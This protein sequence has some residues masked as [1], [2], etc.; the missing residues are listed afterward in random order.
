M[1]STRLLQAAV[2]IGG[3]MLVRADYEVDVANRGWVP[4]FVSGPMSRQG[5]IGYWGALIHVACWITAM[6]LDIVIM[7]LLDYT[8][9]PGLSTLWMYSFISLMVGL[10]SVVLISGYHFCSRSE[11]R[12]PEGGLPPFLMTLFTGGAAI[13]AI[14][15]VLQIVMVGGSGEE[16]FYFHFDNT[17]APYNSFNDKKHFQTALLE[18]TGFSVMFKVYVCHFL[19][20]N[21]VWAGPA[22]ELEKLT[23][24]ANTV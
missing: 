16:S 24:K 7:N 4:Y 8:H 22:N 13:S 14:F 11:T 23:V 1:A 5:S 6:I 9:A 19:Q 10:V 17:T 20:N 3:K 18:L 12:I 15:S 21:L 2:P